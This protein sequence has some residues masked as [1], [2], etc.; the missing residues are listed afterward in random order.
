M[1]QWKILQL[2][3]RRFLKNVFSNSW[4]DN[5]YYYY[6]YYYFSLIYGRECNVNWYQ[7]WNQCSWHWQKYPAALMFSYR[8]LIK[9][10]VKDC[11]AMSWDEVVRR[12]QSDYKR[13]CEVKE[14]LPAFHK[15]PQYPL[16]MITQ[17][18]CYSTGDTGKPL[19]LKLCFRFPTHI[20]SVFLLVLVC[21]VVMSVK[22]GCYES[23][24]SPNLKMKL[25]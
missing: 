11:R 20:L 23:W 8:D 12:W 10:W 14:R 9:L 18:D 25:Y 1:E 13:V 15:A 24:T 19:A 4:F 3:D 2:V 16:T 22:S 6:Y 5:Y 17:R 7:V 21:T